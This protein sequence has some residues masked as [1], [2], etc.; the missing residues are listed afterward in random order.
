V[1]IAAQTRV[2][3]N[4]DELASA[5]SRLDQGWFAGALHRDDAVLKRADE[6]YAT[7]VKV[8]G[9]DLIEIRIRSAVREGAGGQQGRF[10]QFAHG[11]ASDG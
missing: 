11:S 2:F 9:F 5:L 1:N 7:I 4:Q 3:E 8:D 10:V 6:E